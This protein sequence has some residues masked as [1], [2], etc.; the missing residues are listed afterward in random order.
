M[1]TTEKT[2]HPWQT[3]ELSTIG[4]MYQGVIKRAY[5]GRASPR[6][7]I[8]AMCLQCVGYERSEVTHCSSFACPLHFYRPYQN[9]TTEAIAD[10]KIGT[11]ASAE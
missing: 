1:K 4:P 8:R 7:A 6:S 11:E 3:K 9:D 5:E 10:T 2:I